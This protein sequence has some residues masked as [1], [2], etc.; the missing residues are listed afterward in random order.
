MT[1]AHNRTKFCASFK[2]KGQKKKELGLQ[3]PPVTCKPTQSLSV[4]PLAQLPHKQDTK[5][6]VWGSVKNISIS[7][8]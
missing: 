3:C 6:L 8:L 2:A 1:E 7:K 5:S 4:L